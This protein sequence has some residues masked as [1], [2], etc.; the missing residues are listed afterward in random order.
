M[1][2]NIWVVLL[3]IGGGYF[4]Y[5]WYQGLEPAAQLDFQTAMLQDSASLSIPARSRR[6]R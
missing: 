4:V 1:F 3:V 2:G 5:R 6:T